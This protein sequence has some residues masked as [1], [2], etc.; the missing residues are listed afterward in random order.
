MKRFFRLEKARQARAATNGVL[1]D[2]GLYYLVG[3]VAEANEH[4]KRLYKNR[5]L[6]EFSKLW[7]DLTRAGYDETKLR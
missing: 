6:S 3:S 7:A 1:V 5:S 2:M 4:Y